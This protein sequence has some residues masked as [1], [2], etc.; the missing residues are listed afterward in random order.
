MIALTFV[1]YYPLMHTCI[2]NQTYHLLILKHKVNNRQNDNCC[3]GVDAIFY[4]NSLTGKDTHK[5]FRN[6]PSKSSDTKRE[7]KHALP[8]SNT[9]SSFHPVKTQAQSQG[10]I[11]HSHPHSHLAAGFHVHDHEHSAEELKHGALVHEHDHS[12]E[13]LKHGLDRNELQHISKEPKHEL[14]YGNQDVRSYDKHNIHNHLHEHN[15]DLEQ[16]SM[17]KTR[18]RR[19]KRR[20]YFPRQYLQK[21]EQNSHFGVKTKD[22]F[23][24]FHLSKVNRFENAVPVSKPQQ[25]SFSKRHHNFEFHTTDH[26]NQY[27]PRSFQESHQSYYQPVHG[28]EKI[29]RGVSLSRKKP[30]SQVHHFKPLVEVQ[31]S[32]YKGYVE[33]PTRPKQQ[34]KISPQQ[35][36]IHQNMQNTARKN[37]GK[38][39]LQ[40]PLL[41][42]QPNHYE[43]L[44]HKL[45]FVVPKDQRFP[46]SS[47]YEQHNQMLKNQPHRQ[48]S[49]EQGTPFDEDADK[50]E[51]G[52]LHTNAVWPRV[53]KNFNHEI[54]PL[55]REEQTNNAKSFSPSSHGKSEN[56]K[57]TTNH[58]SLQITRDNIVE[59][60]VYKGNE[61]SNITNEVYKGN[62]GT[63]IKNEYEE[64]SQ[65]DTLKEDLKSSINALDNGEMVATEIDN[66]EALSTR[67]SKDIEYLLFFNIRF[68]HIFSTISFYIIKTMR[69]LLLS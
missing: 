67:K 57:K 21:V 17:W 49:V 24:L 40:L 33:Q 12:F 41:P 47:W 42:S 15:K 35:F 34:T 9:R 60:K 7:R 38:N 2:C 45:F 5:H 1:H 61:D 16:D 14:Y 55:V 46:I 10:V 36:L 3:L 48:D 63:E 56:I 29:H 37:L 6:E 59:S 44:S 11:L 4:A 31:P 58:Q 53:L 52:V 64:E 32:Y 68:C 69:Y 39:Q 65:N 23:K 30:H 19:T 13:E 27:H 51:D 28:S 20:E 43:Q 54:I 8:R 26:G 66:D 25:S 22:H 50:T 62:K 18:I